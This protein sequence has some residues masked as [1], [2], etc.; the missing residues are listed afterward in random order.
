MDGAERR[1]ARR[2]RLGFFM[3]YTL[4]EIIAKIRAVAAQY[5]IREALAIEQIRQESR[6]DPHAV[7][8]AGALGIAQFIRSTGKLY[9]LIQDEDFF[10]VTK[11]LDA[12]GRHM[13]DLLAK[14]AGDEKLALAAY[15]AGP[16]AV[17]KYGGVPP[18][19]ETQNYVNTI[20][21]RAGKVG[22]VLVAVGLIAALFLFVIRL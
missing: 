4:T 20:L 3:H 13:R 17:K 5:G 12:Y 21:A 9:G 19:K 15:N 14:Y 10:N 11:A 8:P 1:G 7:S 6:F 22:D 18:Y 2:R 16:G